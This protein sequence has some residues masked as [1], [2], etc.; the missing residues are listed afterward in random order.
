VGQV[1]TDNRWENWTPEELT[2]IEAALTAIAPLAPQTNYANLMIILESLREEIKRRQLNS[3]P[4]KFSALS[5]SDLALLLEWA[6]F[7]EDK[8]GLD[9]HGESIRDEI[10]NERKQRGR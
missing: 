2:L 10:L 8:I 3:K 1:Q 7:V 5:D 9:P 4:T 6:E